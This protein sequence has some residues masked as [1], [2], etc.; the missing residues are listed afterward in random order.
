MAKKE[1]VVNLVREWNIQVD[2]LCQFLP[3]D[4]VAS[5]AA[6]SPQQILRET[7]KA[8][9]S[10]ATLQMHDQLILLHQKEKS[11]ESVKPFLKRSVI[12]LNHIYFRLLKIWDNI[13]KI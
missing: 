9:G 12:D 13:Y 1:E 11:F 5:F 4:R 10:E 8:V 6:L 7:E 2:N 3:Q